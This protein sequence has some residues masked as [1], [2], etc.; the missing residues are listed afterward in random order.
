[1]KIKPEMQQTVEVIEK[2][3]EEQIDMEVVRWFAR[4]GRAPD[5]KKRWLEQLR[6]DRGDDLYSDLVFTLVGQRYPRDE[7]RRTWDAIVT[8]RDQLSRLLK[9][10]PGIVVAALDW[11][12]NFQ[13]DITDELSLIES[14]K[15]E[16][17]LERAIVDGLTGLYDHDTFIIL[18]GKEIE[19]ARRHGENFAL[20]ML[21]LDDFKQ[22]NDKY[23]HQKGDEVLARMAEIMR[24]TVRTMDIPGRYGGEEF[25]V[26]LPETDI[27]ASIQ[28]A[29]RLLEAVKMEFERDVGL[30]V[31][32]GAACF[33]EHAATV[34]TLIR[35]ADEALY[36]AKSE[37]KNRIVSAKN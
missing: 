28:S 2:L 37:G 3:E 7:A 29:E 16:N 19:R 21:D 13:D 33:P 8:H 36:K 22:I 6:Q 18:L 23:G 10:N 5:S 1:M 4:E 17:V 32:I 15:L 24:E 14:G 35:M 11:M 31:S 27:R 30:T 9:R 34:E 20:L 12:T 25:A 26:I